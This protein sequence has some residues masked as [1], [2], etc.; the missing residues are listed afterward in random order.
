MKRSILAIPVAVV[1]LA[2]AAVAAIAHSSGGGGST[3]TPVTASAYGDA[4]MP[5]TASAYATST[6]ATITTASHGLGTMLVDA[7]GRTLYL[8]KADTGHKSTCTGAC[9][10]AWP[11]V[12]TKG[13]PKAHG[14]A[15]A[16]LLSTTKR[17]D[18]TTQVTYAGHPL[19]RFQGDAKAGQHNG[20]ASKA[21]GAD[22][23]VVAPNGKAITRGDD[24]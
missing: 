23:L 8:W 15:K 10:T 16:S 24:S 17:S 22:W 7:Q 2:I 18:G 4:S 19:Y 5:A 11:P 13:K 12:T 1:V 20:Q 14:A 3:G 6:S 9:A 21:F